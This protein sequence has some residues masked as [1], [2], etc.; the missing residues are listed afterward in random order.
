MANET[1]EELR[2]M[3]NT[4]KELL[5]ELARQNRGT[6]KNTKSKTTQDDRQEKNGNVRVKI[7]KKKLKCWTPEETVIML[8]RVLFPVSFVVSVIVLFRINF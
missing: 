6:V 8:C 4:L 3:H 1:C 5:V 7:Q 2:N